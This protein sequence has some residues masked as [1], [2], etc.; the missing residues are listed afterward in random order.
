MNMT[1]EQAIEWLENSP[2]V[3]LI[4]GKKREV[5][6]TNGMTVQVTGIGI[7]DTTLMVQDVLKQM[8]EGG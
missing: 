7:V 5:T 2:G 3:T 1:P 4:V 8:S 6:I